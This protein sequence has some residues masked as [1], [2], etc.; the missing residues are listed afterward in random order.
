MPS[1]LQAAVEVNNDKLPKNSH[2]QQVHKMKNE[3]FIQPVV[4]TVRRTNCQ[5]SARCQNVEQCHTKDKYQL[6]KVLILLRHFADIN[7]EEEQ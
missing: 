3:A 7:C 4:I 6:P 5:D 2:I 1:Q